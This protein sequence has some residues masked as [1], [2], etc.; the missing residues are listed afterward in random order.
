MAAIH[1]QYNSHMGRPD[2]RDPGSMTRFIK[3]LGR[4]KVSEKTPNLNAAHELLTQV[5]EGHVLT[6]LMHKCRVQNMQELDRKV[7]SGEW[8]AQVED[9]VADLA[10][11][12]VDT[13]REEA[14]GQAGSE[15]D[16][17]E[18]QAH[19]EAASQ[20]VRES[21]AQQQSRRKKTV[22]EAVLQRRDIVYENAILF[23][24]HSLIYTD[25]CDSIRSGDTG[26]LEKSLDILMVMFQGLPKMK[27]YRY[28]TLDFKALRTRLWTEEMRELWLWNAV[29]NLSGQ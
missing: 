10:F 23:L 14:E 12:H 7:E 8:K 26:R 15:F 11:D 4:T 3:L 20:V 21:A 25:F 5:S 18:M 16:D 13:L 29:L 19:T 2:G 27:N 28:Q 6:A 24:T 22:K 1:M 17:A 9:M